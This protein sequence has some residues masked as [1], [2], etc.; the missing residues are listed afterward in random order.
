M[1]NFCTNCGKPLSQDAKFCANCGTPIAI[2]SPTLKTTDLSSIPASSIDFSNIGKQI[3]QEVKKY[4]NIFTST[5]LIKLG[6]NGH[7]KIDSANKTF[8]IE[9]YDTALKGLF[10]QKMTR[11]RKAIKKTYKFSQL[12][13]F[14]IEEQHNPL[15]SSDK[16]FLKCIMAPEFRTP[17]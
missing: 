8:H 3:K 7:I 12:L 6:L 14:K 10:F 2:I 15:L 16:A 4:V 5:S 1:N 13:N 9:L 17:V 11:T